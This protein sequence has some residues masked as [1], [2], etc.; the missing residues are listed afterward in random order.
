M[1]GSVIPLNTIHLEQASVY[2]E[3]VIT[4][5][6]GYNPKQDGGVQST[7]LGRV[8]FKDIRAE[9]EQQIYRQLQTKI[10]VSVQ[11]R[12]N[13][14]NEAEHPE[15]DRNGHYSKWNTAAVFVFGPLL[16]LTLVGSLLSDA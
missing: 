15:H 8:M 9:T 7:L 11:Y 12:I 3:D 4:K 2:L 6:T 14:F 1:L 5:I 10:D 13:R 16:V